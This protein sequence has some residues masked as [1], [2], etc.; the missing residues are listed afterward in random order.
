MMVE[1]TAGQIA[2]L[3]A[4]RDHCAALGADL[5]IGAIAYQVH[6]PG[7]L[8]HSG[9]IDFAVA[10]DLNEF[11]EM[12]RRLQ[13]DGWIRFANREHRWRSA[14]GNNYRSASRRPEASRSQASDLARQPVHHESGGIRACV[15]GRPAG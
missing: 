13:A 1:L 2:D 4:L 11:A 12:E 6:F 10:L 5:V 9:D 3:R 8:R 15:H 14:T 7:E